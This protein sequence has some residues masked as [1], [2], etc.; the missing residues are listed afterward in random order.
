MI[1]YELEE[2]VATPHYM[3]TQT[4]LREICQNK[5]QKLRGSNAYILNESKII[6][7]SFV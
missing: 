3:K 5:G 4:V 2:S 6:G 7:L 1:V